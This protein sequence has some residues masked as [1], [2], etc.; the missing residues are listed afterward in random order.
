VSAGLPSRAEVAT[1]KFWAADAGHR[2]A[3]TAVHIH[4]GMGIDLDHPLHR[5]FI[6]AKRTEFELGSAT[7]QL[8]RLGALLAD[9][10]A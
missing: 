6:A 8:R 9:E 7:T 3:H 5:Y 2:V 10:P 4:G 1:A